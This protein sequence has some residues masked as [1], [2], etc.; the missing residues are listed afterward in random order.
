[1]NR[2]ASILSLTFVPVF[3]VACSGEDSTPAATSQEYVA[4]VRGDLASTA[5]TEAQT[6][7]D[8][9]AEG[10][11]EAALA[12]GNFG[13]DP[14]LGTTMLGTAEN[15][16]LSLDRWDNAD[17]V[18]AFYDTPEFQ[19]GMSALLSG[20][21]SVQRFVRSDWH[22]WGDLDAADALQEKYLVVVRGRLASESTAENQAAH[23]AVAAAGEA[24][25]R[26]AGDVAHVV[27]LGLDD[28]R[29]FLA[30]DVWTT[31]A[32]IEGVYTNPDFQAG[33]AALFAAP[34]EVGVYRGTDWAGW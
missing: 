14:A 13:H 26:G 4:L 24:M 21:V 32:P 33:F 5:L 9:I 10:G 25:V 15:R 17:G 11:Q 31:S 7:H 28:P 23:D 16:F 6:Q 8:A 29:E 34:A 18:R 27:Y 19:G 30:I 1:M 12:A 3:T 20:V 22:E 2:T